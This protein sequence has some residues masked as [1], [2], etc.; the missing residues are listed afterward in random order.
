MVGRFTRA[1]RTTRVLDSI[2]YPS[3][4]ARDLYM[5]MHTTSNRTATM[6]DVIAHPLLKFLGA[7]TSEQAS[8]AAKRVVTDALAEARFVSIVSMDGDVASMLRHKSLKQ[9]YMSAAEEIFSLNLPSD[10]YMQFLIQASISTNGWIPLRSFIQHPRLLRLCVPHE[11]SAVLVLCESD[12]VEVSSID[13]GPMIRRRRTAITPPPQSFSPIHPLRNN[14]ESAESNPAMSE[15][16]APML[17]DAGISIAED[18]QKSTSPLSYPRLLEWSGAARSRCDFTVMSYNILADFQA[19]PDDYPYA[20]KANLAW[21]NR[22]EKIM[23]DIESVRPSIVCLQELQSSDVV[24]DNHTIALFKRM[25]ELGYAGGAYVRK[26]T[27]YNPELGNAVLYSVEFTLVSKKTIHY[28]KEIAA[29]CGDNIDSFDY[30]G[31]GKQTALLV[32]LRHM[33]GRYVLVCNTHIWCNWTETP[34]Q[35]MQVQVFLNQIQA[36]LDELAVD[37]PRDEIAVIL[38][39]DYNSTQSTG[40]YKLITTGK[41]AS[42]HE[43]AHA[44]NKPKVKAL[45]DVFGHDLELVSAY[46]AVNGSEPAA[47]TVH[48]DYIATIDYV[49]FQPSKLA[50]VNVLR[51]PSIEEG[52]VEGGM[53]NTVYGSDHLPVAAAFAFV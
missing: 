46:V 12:I 43:D 4:L 41:L 2:F 53:P 6:D 23:K 28:S 14:A 5:S 38:T 47:T 3:N 29:L 18:A 26:D 40:V 15:E 42:T 50:A 20:S 10:T 36:Y 17:P 34:T 27:T 32:C 24:S 11:A 35:T 44:R 48:G 31:A 16:K 33:S 37:M 30:Y 22:F 52:S 1:V 7:N 39:G 9:V 45:V 19:R 21:P 8:H 51:V 13:S 25:D 49:F